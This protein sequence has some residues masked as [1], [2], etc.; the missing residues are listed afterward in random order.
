MDD[1]PESGSGLSLRNAQ[2]R[3]GETEMTPPPST[4]ADPNAMVDRL[5]ALWGETRWHTCWSPSAGVGVYIHAGRFRKDLDLWWVH[6]AAYLPDNKLAVDRFW[7]R[8]RN[9]AGLS[10]DQL[11]LT[12]TTQ[13]WAATFDGVGQLCDTES[14]TRASRG[15][16]APSVRLRWELSATPLAPVWD[17]YDGVSWQHDFASAGHIQQASA[18]TGT[19]WID[20]H[21]YPLDGV[22]F[23]D[24]SSGARSFQTWVG[25]AFL[26]GEISGRVVH[27]VTIVREDSG[28]QTMG[29]TMTPGEQASVTGFDVLPLASFDGAPHEQKLTI[30]TSAG[31]IALH[32]KLIHAL[33]I[34]ITEANDN[35]NGVDWDLEGDPMIM[36]EGIVA[37]TDER[38]EVGYG[39][40]ERSARRSK[41][42]LQ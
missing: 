26:V 5:T 18:T 25:H 32:A 10:C 20:D 35:F 30:E 24:H 19:L 40:L 4:P 6:V 9:A 13:G 16:S 31:S 12:I 15:S 39:F 36:V 29:V 27:A 7:C 42:G 11:D 33:P 14:L 3:T 1:L 41:R 2:E 22:G 21:A 38:G 8:N 28:A 17:M 23:K 34:T 37:L